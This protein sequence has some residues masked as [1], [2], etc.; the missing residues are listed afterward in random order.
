MADWDNKPPKL[1][2]VLGPTASGKTA[3]ALELARRF[4]A[5][6]VSA[7]SMQIYRGLDIGTAKVTAQEAA[8]IPHHLIDI[9]EADCPFSVA[10]Y[11]ARAHAAVLEITARGRLPLVTGGTGL[12]ISSLL[13][14]LRFVDTPPVDTLRAR[15]AAEA[16]AE[17]PEAMWR[18]LQ[19]VDPAAAAA[20]HPHNVKRVLR[21]LEL[22]RQTG[23][24]MAEQAAASRPAA[25]P[26]DALVLGLRF[27]DRAALYARIDRRVDAMMDAGLLKEAR[28]VY[29]H[30]AQYATAAQAI[31]YKEF[32]PYF[33]GECT[34]EDSVEA[35]KRASRR[36][37]K[38]Q[39]T[40]FERM[41]AVQ[42]LPAD[43][44]PTE[45]A[46]AAL[47]RHLQQPGPKKPPQGEGQA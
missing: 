27:A 24:T 26:Y 29:E 46:A 42:W 33:A 41:P 4:D 47:Q 15:L 7:D 10:D 23:C 21:A 14:G 12:Y 36:Y 3:L 9:C 22:N 43:P 6:I 17:G 45:Q 18:R 31:G 20:I 2:V 30:R 11:V 25:A 19:A 16:A 40:W 34:L 13:Q 28:C 39:M 32:F 38:R 37:A 44:P 35:L 1:A 5:E 8:G